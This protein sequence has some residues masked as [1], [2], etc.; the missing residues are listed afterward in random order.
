MHPTQVRLAVLTFCLALA[1]PLAAQPP[2]PQPAPG[3]P[4]PFADSRAIP[5]TA[6]YRRA[7][8]VLALVNAGDAARVRAY[9]D[10]AF[11]PALRDRAPLE[12]HVGVFADVHEGSGRFD[13]H[14]A[15]S[16]TPPR[17]GT[18]AVLIVR[19]TLLEAWEAI[20][21]EV[22]PEAP[23]RLVSL[24]FNR[25]RTPTDVPPAKPATDAEIARQLGALVDRLAVAGRFSGAVLFAR[26][27]KVLLSKAIGVANRDFDAPVTIDTKF[28]LGSMNKM[29]TAVAMMRL[30]E[31]GKVSLDDPLSRWLDESWLPRAILD[32]VKVKHL[33]THTSG[34]GSYFNEAYQRS[35]REL[36][37][38]VSDYRPLVRG[39][40]LRFEPGADWSYSNTGMLLAGAVIEEASGQD[41]FDFVREQVCRPAGMTA[42]DCY[43]LDEVNPNLAVGYNRNLADGK[44]VYRNNLYKHVMRGGPAG[45]GYSTV[46]DLLRFDRALRD[47]RLLKK[48]SLEALW[49]P[50]PELHSPEYGLGF[51]VEQGPAGRAVGHSGGFFGISSDLL[52]YLDS[53]HT[54]AVLTNQ[55][56]AALPV[57]PFVTRMLGQGR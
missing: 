16:Y 25:A 20:V 12:E 4:A 40:T 8:E 5:A 30:V 41:Y 27:G 35:S 46:G 9:A 26:D 38:A 11:A 19:N 50:Y 57:T 22:E 15:R 39:D 47:G 37:R 55:G 6:A 43:A 10:S 29:F 48:E 51:G 23:H 13:V 24:E 54:I 53:G 21:T 34:L 49:R 3:A 52:M 36:F 33:L 44:P 2:S 32:R 17:P 1:A 31:Q 14:G 28:N 42:T 45:G 7:R 56:G 18:Q